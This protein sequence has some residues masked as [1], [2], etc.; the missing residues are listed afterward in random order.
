MLTCTGGCFECGVC[1]V[2]AA[3]IVP[4]LEARE[5]ARPPKPNGW[6][7]RTMRGARVRG[8]DPTRGSIPQQRAAFKR[9][10]VQHWEICICSAASNANNT[11]TKCIG[12]TLGR[13]KVALLLV[14]GTLCGH[15]GALC[16]PPP[17][18][19]QGVHQMRLGRR[20]KSARAMHPPS[21]LHCN[22]ARQGQGEGIL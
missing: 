16:A 13:V 2:T 22:T 12:A 8:P 9:S 4:G 14:W 3:Q 1:T 20:A 17:G 7:A 10:M 21:L 11:P 19:F 6:V 18:L 5:S 15:L